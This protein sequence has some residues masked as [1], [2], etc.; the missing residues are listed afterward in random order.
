MCQL[1]TSGPTPTWGAREEKDLESGCEW[2]SLGQRHITHSH[3]QPGSKMALLSNPVLM[4]SEQQAPPSQEGSGKS[5]VRHFSGLCFQKQPQG[6]WFDECNSINEGKG[7]K[8]LK[9]K[10]VTY[11]IWLSCDLLLF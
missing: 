11:E 3:P 4:A 2:S 10:G 7:L 1:F 8:S 5:W 9:K 6:P